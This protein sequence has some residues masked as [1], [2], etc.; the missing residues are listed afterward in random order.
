MMKWIA[1]FLAS[2]LIVS[3]IVAWIWGKINPP[4]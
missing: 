3:L 2:W 4:R 1:I